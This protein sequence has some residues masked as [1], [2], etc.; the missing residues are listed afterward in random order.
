MKRIILV[1]IFFFNLSI[2]FDSGTVLVN[3]ATRVSAQGMGEEEMCTPGMDYWDIVDLFPMDDIDYTVASTT[4]FTE[5]TG[6]LGSVEIGGVDF[7][8]TFND[9]TYEW[10]LISYFYSEQDI[11][12]FID[13]PDY[14]N[15][16]VPTDPDNWVDMG[17]KYVGDN[18]K[19]VQTSPPQESMTSCDN[20]TSQVTP[21][22]L[23]GYMS[24]SNSILETQ[25]GELFSDG[26]LPFTDLRA[27]ANSMLALF[28]TNTSVSTVFSDSRLTAK[29]ESS[30]EFQ[31][32]RTDVENILKGVMN[33]HSG[34]LASLSY[35]PLNNLTFSTILQQ[36]T[37]LGILLHTIYSIKAE[38][39]TYMVKA[40]TKE[41]YATVKYTF[42][43]DF[44]LDANDLIRNTAF[45][46]FKAWYILQHFRCYKPFITEVVINTKLNGHYN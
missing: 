27:V 40:S 23:S 4:G 2:Q 3:A 16:T 42:R 31:T 5:F 44:G 30:S 32:Y 38:V 43:D 9:Y 15:I 28:K 20:P 11:P 12:I 29:V 22:G 39:T 8:Y 1:V 34:S 21:L 13:D 14:W 33:T 17:Y 24:L 10:E 37:G 45:P 26:T 35:Q 41:Y 6:D 19:T 18:A 46:N 36:L 25:M 7:L